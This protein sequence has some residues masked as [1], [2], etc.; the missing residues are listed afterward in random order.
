MS[1]FLGEITEKDFH[2]I[3][4]ITSYTTRYTILRIAIVTL[5]GA[6]FLLLATN[7]TSDFEQKIPFHIYIQVITTFVLL[8]EANVLF[9]NLAERFFPIPE[10]I[11]SR[12]VIHF[13]ISVGLGLISIAYF[14]S[15][16]IVENILQQRIVWLLI[17]LGL[18][19]IFY[20]IMFSIGLRITEKWIWSMKEID[21]LREAH[22]INEYNS[23]QDQLNPHFL[24]N[25]LSV[26]KSL[27]I[28]NPEAAATFIQ[29]FTDVYRYV[30]QNAKK[31][32]VQLSDELTVIKSYLELHR[33]RLGNAMIVEYDIKPESTD[34]EIAPMA[35]QLLV[36]N[37]LKHNVVSKK[38]P[39][40]IK[41]KSTEEW[42]EVSNN[43]NPKE[44]TYSTQK[45]LS[46]LSQRVRWLTSKDIKI[47]NNE[48]EFKV[49]VP[50]L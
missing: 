29:N 9:A 1:R 22:L 38:Q 21:Q 25:N 3:S 8:S 50:L 48:N 24:F 12:I 2:F 28:Y 37:A 4:R 18:F 20:L 6:L 44:S 35:L 40:T 34:R 36:E 23:L 31:P 27:I 11:K 47:E 33:E 46:N 26:L 15:L 45:G 39:L 49:K 5:I 30:L 19:F 7:V 14:S 13:I 43:L 10:K 32:S 42:V 41:I 16:N 17:A